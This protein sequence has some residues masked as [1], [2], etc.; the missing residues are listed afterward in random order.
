M[1]ENRKAQFEESMDSAKY[2]TFKLE[3]ETYG[4]PILRVQEIIGMMKI[5]KFPKAPDYVRGVINLRGKVIPVVELRKKFCV[6]SVEDDDKTCIIVLSLNDDSG[7]IRQG[8]IVDEVSEVMDIE[9]TKIEQPPDFGSQ[10]QE[11][12]ITGVGK[13]ND[14][15]IILLDVDKLL[16]SELSNE[17]TLKP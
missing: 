4:L 7:G 16:C 10:Q 14:K 9:N 15:V 13:T 12:F 1:V 11:E 17:L 8:I 2:L 3:K 6:Q 5:T